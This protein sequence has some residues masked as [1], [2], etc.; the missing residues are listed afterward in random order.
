M[1]MMMMA[2]KMIRKLKVL[3]TADFWDE[4]FLD[5]LTTGLITLIILTF[6]LAKQ[7]S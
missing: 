5:F 4:Y 6:I 1:M 7:S 3:G 2:S